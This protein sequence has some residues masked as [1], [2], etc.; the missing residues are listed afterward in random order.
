MS[1]ADWF[2]ALTFLVGAAFFAYGVSRIGRPA[3]RAR[4]RER[5]ADKRVARRVA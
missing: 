2:L 5:R 4:E 3:E 1:F